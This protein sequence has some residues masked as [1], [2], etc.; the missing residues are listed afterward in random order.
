[1][2]LDKEKVTTA[3]TAT[4]RTIRL[5]STS[6][7]ITPQSANSSSTAHHTVAA[8]NLVFAQIM[9]DIR[10]RATANQPIAKSL[11]WPI[12]VVVFQH[13]VE[14]VLQMPFAEHKEVIQ[15]LVL[16]R[17]N[18]AFAMG[19]HHRLFGTYA[20]DLDTRVLD[21]AIKAWSEVAVQVAN[22][23]SRCG[24]ALFAHAQ[25]RSMPVKYFEKSQNLLP[26]FRSVYELL[27]R[28]GMQERCWNRHATSLQKASDRRI[29]AYRPC[30]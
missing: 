17:A 15:H 3:H 5:E 24:I 13:L 26:V 25:A 18:D 19:I 7:S 10:R 4:L 28:S 29:F 23:M 9:I 1:V 12:G 14:Q 27:V 8:N 2:D 20:H 6:T 21:C 22:Q 11:M 16:N 30:V